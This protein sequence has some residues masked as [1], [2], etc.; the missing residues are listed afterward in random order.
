M[1]SEDEEDNLHKKLEATVQAPARMIKLIHEW[2]NKASSLRQAESRK[3][4][5]GL[6][7][8]EETKVRS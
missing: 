2:L 4:I 8:D 1:D 3:E 7:G 6:I 5:N